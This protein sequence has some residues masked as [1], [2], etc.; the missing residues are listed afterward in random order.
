M[1]GFGDQPAESSR[2]SFDSAARFAQDDSGPLLETG[3]QKRTAATRLGLFFDCL[4]L[5]P[6]YLYISLTPSTN[7]LSLRLRLG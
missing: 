1:K 2:R 6:A 4:L 3:D 7:A 5:L